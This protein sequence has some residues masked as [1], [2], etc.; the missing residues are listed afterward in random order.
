[1]IPDRAASHRLLDRVIEQSHRVRFPSRR[2]AVV[3]ASTAT[4][5]AAVAFP[6]GTGAAAATPN[7]KAGVASAVYL[8]SDPA[9]LVGL[10]ASWAYDWSAKIPASN[11]GID[12][13]PMIWSQTYATPQIIESLRQA[14]EDGSAR[15]LLG[16]NEP[17]NPAQANMSPARA[18]ELW[19][20][21]EQTGLILGSPAPETPTDGWLKRFMLLARERHLQV[22]FI[23]LH[24]YMDFTNPSSVAAMRAQLIQVHNTYHLPIWITELGALDIRQWGQRML[25]PGDAVQAQV[26]MRNVFRMLDRLSFVKRYAW[27]TDSCASQSGCRY[28]SLFSTTGAVTAEGREY[29]RDA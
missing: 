23:A 28:S 4:G 22:N 16:F 13:V 3:L 9:K 10:N 12:W 27:Y 11:P 18:A 8:D 20:Q 5:L 6:T 25:H 15:Y 29:R 1:M 26:Y 14:R 21:L 24:Y 19:P 7:T 2:L 17:D